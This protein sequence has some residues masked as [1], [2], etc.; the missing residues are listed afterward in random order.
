MTELVGITIDVLAKRLQRIRK[1]DLRAG[2]LVEI[3]KLREDLAL[4]LAFLIGLQPPGGDDGTVATAIDDCMARIVAMQF[5]ISGIMICGNLPE[6]ISESGQSLIEGLD[7]LV[8]RFQYVG[9]FTFPS[10]LGYI[11]GALVCE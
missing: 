11:E 2:K 6:Y 10:L 1:S 9:C 8:A 5:H 3:A 7:E 4:L